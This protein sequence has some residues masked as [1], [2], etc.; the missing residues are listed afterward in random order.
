MSDRDLLKTIREQ[1]KDSESAMRPLFDKAKR[2]LR[3]ANGDQWDAEVRGSL[4]ARGKFSWAFNLIWK[5]LMVISGKE[6][7]GRSD[8]RALPEE[9]SDDT[10]AD[11]IS[12]VL[13]WQMS[14]NYGSY[15]LSET[16]LTALKIGWGWISL[17]IRRDLTDIL[18]DPNGKGEA[19]I[20]QANP[21]SVYPDRRWTRFDMSDCHYI[22]HRVKMPLSEIKHR[23]RKFESEIDGLRKGS[24]LLPDFIKP[25]YD[26]SDLLEVIARWSREYVRRTLYIDVV[27]G[28]VTEESPEFLAYLSTLPADQH[29]QVQRLVVDEPRMRMDLL[30]ED[31][32]TIPSGWSNPLEISTFPLIPVRCYFDSVEEQWASKMFGLV[33]G[34]CDPQEL[35]NKLLN[36]MAYQMATTPWRTIAVGPSNDSV[37][38]EEIL[39]AGNEHG[40]R[41]LRLRNLN[42]MKEMNGNSFDPKILNVAELM[43]DLFNYIGNNPDLQGQ[44]SDP[45]APGIATQLRQAQGDSA[46]EPIY[47]NLRL[48]M[49]MFAR[50][51]IELTGQCYSTR[52][53]RRIVG[54]EVEVPDDIQQRIKD[55]R[56]DISVQ[57]FSQSP[58]YRYFEYA[59]MQELMQ[60][61][62]LNLPVD[63]AEVMLELADVPPQLKERIVSFM[64]AQSQPPVGG[65]EAGAGAGAPPPQGGSGVD[66]VQMLSGQAQQAGPAA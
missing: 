29:Q 22:L 30:F 49:E 41:I 16:L 23:Y 55:A 9:G 20:G 42:D 34:L 44:V 14:R 27:H 35:F 47:D 61:G 26:D 54:D 63:L 32:L 5:H 19:V 25:G 39:D 11:L 45:G 58:T 17:D 31:Q 43:K 3:F 60:N 28:D 50:G 21:F 40:V 33:R 36:E 15:H 65:G 24:R 13:K 59:K 2:D 6:R 56:F 53:F 10:L 51:L 18:A 1:A 46:N 52:K 66:L 57:L 12:R 62:L 48:S 8:M 7:Q 38:A 37:S 4:D 64:R